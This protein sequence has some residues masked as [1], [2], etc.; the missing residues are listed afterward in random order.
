MRGRSSSAVSFDR[1]RPGSVSTAAAL[2]QGTTIT[3]AA[4]RNSATPCR[5]AAA[6][7]IFLAHGDVAGCKRCA[8]QHRCRVRRGSRRLNTGMAFRPR[9][10]H[11]LAEALRTYID[12]AGIADDRKGF[13][14]RASCGQRGWETATY[15]E[16]SNMAL[17]STL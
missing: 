13:L 11:P 1:S 5:S 6:N 16:A 3:S 2:I 14:F 10:H 9:G 7:E 17:C 4:T 12:A 8:E 15:S